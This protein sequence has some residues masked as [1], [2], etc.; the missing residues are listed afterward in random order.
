MHHWLYRS[1]DMLLE[2]PPLSLGALADC[3]YCKGREHQIPQIGQRIKFLSPNYGETGVRVD[4]RHYNL[5]LD[6]F[7]VKMDYEAIDYV[8][9]VTRFM[10]LYIV[11]PFASPASWMPQFSIQD[12]LA[13]H[14]SMLRVLDMLMKSHARKP[15][16]ECIGPIVSACWR[17]R[18][19]ISGH[20]IW[21][22]LEAHGF[23]ETQRPEFINLFEFGFDLLIRTH[24]RPPIKR[25][26][27]APLS[28]GRYLSKGNRE[29]YLRHF[30]HNFG[31]GSPHSSKKLT[32]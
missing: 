25:K 18:L 22:M 29:I 8:Q 17:Q 14:E 19:P 6:Q 10:D 11:E 24:G 16:H 13:I 2:K 7:A 32:S 12:V 5:R 9:T 21:P 31:Y 15:L 4:D 30:G 28:K 27:M 20:E 1:E 3:P 23:A 26:R